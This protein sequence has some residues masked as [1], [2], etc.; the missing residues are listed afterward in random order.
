MWNECV[1]TGCFLLPFCPCLIK[2]KFWISYWNVCKLQ[3]QR[4]CLDVTDSLI[5]YTQHPKFI[6]QRKKLICFLTTHE[7][8][9]FLYMVMGKIAIFSADHIW[10]ENAPASL[11]KCASNT[12]ACKQ[13]TIKDVKHYY[14]LL[15]LAHSR[16]DKY[17]T[18]IHWNGCKCLNPLHMH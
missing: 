5:S 9:Y 1:L 16:A 4:M 10:D 11:W 2:N 14:F 8:T 13:W 15:Y 18:I 12:H 3:S 17:K 7:S 6:C